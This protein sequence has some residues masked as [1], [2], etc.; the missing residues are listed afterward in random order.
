LKP[1]HPK[2]TVM[3]K[4]RVSAPLVIASAVT[5]C[6]LCLTLAAPIAYADALE[7]VRGAVNTSRSNTP[8]PALNYNGDLEGAAQTY[9]R[10]N[11]L[12]TPG[13]YQG[14]THGFRGT[15]DPQAQAISSA[16]S[17]GHFPAAIEDCSYKD[18]GVGFVRDSN[19]DI[20]TVTIVF[21][22][23]PAAKPAPP[24]GPV[25]PVTTPCPD[26]S[27]VPAGQACPVKPPPPPPPPP[28]VTNAIALSF[29]PPHLGSITATIKNSSNLTAKCTYDASGITKTHRDFTV[30]PQGSTDLTFNGFNTG[31]SY[32]VVVS[33]HDAGGKQTQE[34]GHAETDVTF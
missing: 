25:A 1:T 33:C 4:T 26:G 10:S 22:A 5:G 20:D 19:N 12:Q 23:P 16:M 30:S 9:A 15:G 6:A 31:S 32:H 17:G 24:A 3:T 29:G 27:T 8:C 18:F 14:A 11:K 28:P 34:I 2:E 7:P 13:G 21:G